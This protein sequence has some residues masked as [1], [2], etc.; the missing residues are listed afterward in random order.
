MKNLLYIGTLIIITG[1]FL[2]GCSELNEDI[3]SAPQ[4]LKYHE[5]G[6]G[7]MNSP[8]NH[9]VLLRNTN[10]ETNSCQ[11][12]HAA[13][14]G[15]GVAGPTCLD[16][17][18]QPGG[19]FACNTCH[20]DLSNP[21]RIAPPR[22]INGNTSTTLKSVGAH[23][24]HL[25][26]NSKGA[27]APCESCHKVPSNVYDEGHLDNI[28]SVHF[29]GRAKLFGAENAVYDASTGT[30]SNTYCHGNFVFY[31]DSADVTNRFAYTSDRMVGLNKTVSWTKVNQGEAE[32]GSC[33]GLPPEGHIVVPLTS[34]YQCHQGV[35]DPQ[36]NIIDKEKHIN[37]IANS[38][39]N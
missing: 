39:G 23:E 2:N 33:H 25:Y 29:S 18:T 15:G 3:T 26:T 17:H 4:K 10:W 24:V 20:G 21:A 9:K 38:R 16:C 28:S 1:I 36:G 27:A 14:F 32:C 5:S 35:V 6:F 7:D 19:P 31:R 37:G 30:C 13:N 12:C 11:Q 34:C 8:N 22:D